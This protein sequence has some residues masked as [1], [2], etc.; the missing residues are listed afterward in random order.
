MSGHSS[1]LARLSL[2][3][4]A[5]DTTP[6]NPAPFENSMHRLITIYY[7][8]AYAKAY[9]YRSHNQAMAF[10]LT[11]TQDANGNIKTPDINKIISHYTFC[12]QEGLNLLK[13]SVNFL[14]TNK[15]VK[16]KLDERLRHKL[17]D[18]HAKFRM[19]I[20]EIKDQKD[21]L[22]NKRL[23]IFNSRVAL[24]LETFFPNTNVREFLN[25]ARESSAPIA[26]APR[27]YVSHA[28]SF[29]TVLEPMP[30]SEASIISTYKIKD[31]QLIFQSHVSDGD[32]NEKSPN[33]SLEKQL[34]HINQ[35]LERKLKAFLALDSSIF[36]F[37]VSTKHSEIFNLIASETALEKK[38]LMHALLAR[39]MLD[40]NADSTRTSI[41][42]ILDQFRAEIGNAQ[43]N[44]E[45]WQLA[46]DSIIYEAATG[47]PMNVGSTNRPDKTEMVLVCHQILNRL[48]QP[49][50]G[51]L[52]VTK[53]SFIQARDAVINSGF[54]QL[55]THRNGL[56]AS[57][58]EASRVF[59][60][61]KDSPAA[62]ALCSKK[63]HRSGNLKFNDKGAKRD[64]KILYLLRLAKAL[65]VQQSAENKALPDINIGEHLGRGIH[66]FNTNSENCSLA[67]NQL[68]RIKLSGHGA[69][70]ENLIS[71]QIK[72]ATLF[73]T[74][75][76]ASCN[77][78]STSFSQ[79]QKESHQKAFN[80]A[81]GLPNTDH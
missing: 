2:E 65:S 39:K 12:L 50:T 35:G 63:S 32:V 58:S 23:A 46:L 66:F 68:F 40:F 43:P 26:S 47:T 44:Y 57:R 54:P 3:T 75:L 6:P 55:M 20:D 49:E 62:K 48:Y 33:I 9:Q 29:I 81:L 27:N 37:G 53:K 78:S 45:I 64:L 34:N 79:S 70:Q 59:G 14:D 67:L 60:F 30:D 18:L 76:N 15:L 31:S 4:V 11:P 24:L 8:E 7:A 52:N 5:F 42:N 13:N 77:K 19:D 1:S 72:A 10:V 74:V 41:P 25:K 71:L 73:E 17:S 22:L 16:T 38:R 80:Q 69:D 51:F 28:G 36:Q 21:T 61:H 56:Q